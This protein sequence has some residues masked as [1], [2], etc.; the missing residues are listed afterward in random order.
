MQFTFTTTYNMEALTAMSRALRKTTG[1]AHSERM[2][3]IGFTSAAGGVVLAILPM[4]STF[5]FI[6]SKVVAAFVIILVAVAFFMEDKLNAKLIA[7]QMN[8]Q[9]PT[10]TAKFD[11][12]HYVTTT[13]GMKTEWS[14]TDIRQL[15][16]SEYYFILLFDENNVQV[17]DKRTLTGG[18]VDEFRSFITKAGRMD[19]RR[20]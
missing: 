8:G 11:K 13:D 18:T 12:M 9:E 16:E 15:A 4:N 6:A 14:Y 10:V 20:V 3:L 5:S 2:R 1:K 7:G 19:M 17:Y